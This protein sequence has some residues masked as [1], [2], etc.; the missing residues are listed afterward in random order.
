M[1]TVLFNNSQAIYFVTISKLKIVYLQN[2]TQ[3]NNKLHGT[4][5][6][7][8]ACLQRH[9]VQWFSIAAYGLAQDLKTV[10]FS[11]INKDIDRIGRKKKNLNMLPIQHT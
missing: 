6:L 8:V 10:P 2:Y 5:H 11:H 7:A 4:V 3:K 9:F 1:P